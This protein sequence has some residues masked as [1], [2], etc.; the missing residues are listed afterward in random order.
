[1]NKKFQLENLNGKHHL[2]DQ[3]VDGRII[4]T[5]IIVRNRMVQ[6]LCEYTDWIHL[7]QDMNQWR[8]IV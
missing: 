8:A 3:A 4:T 6:K 2:I 1:V 7:A 5:L